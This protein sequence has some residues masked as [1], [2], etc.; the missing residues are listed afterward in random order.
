MMMMMIINSYYL[1]YYLHYYLNYADDLALLAIINIQTQYVQHS[2]EQATRGNCLYV[3]SNRIEFIPFYQDGAIS[4]LNRK[5]LK[6]IEETPYLGGYISSIG[7]DFHR[8]IGKS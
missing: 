3:D 2:I 7:C 6:G 4:S 8:Y 5:P 1:H